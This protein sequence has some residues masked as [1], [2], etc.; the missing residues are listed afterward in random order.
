MKV[1]KVIWNENICTHSGNC[2]RSLPEVF[3]LKGDQFVINEQG[4]DI[5]RIRT[6]V[7]NCPS[8]ALNLVP[9]EGTTD[10]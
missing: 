2:V 4:A 8:G 1:E 9:V 3:M 6:V 5:S 10:H 7:E